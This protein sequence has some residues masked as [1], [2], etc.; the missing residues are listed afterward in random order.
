MKVSRNWLNKWVDVTSIADSE[1][2]KTFESLGYEVE[3]IIEI[4]P[5]Y[6][7]VVVGTVTNIQNHPN[8]DKIRIVDVDIGKNNLQIICGAWN[9][10]TNDKVAVAVPG[11]SIS[12]DFKIET[13]DI[14]GVT[15]NGMICSP[16]ELDLWSESE[17]ILILDESFINGTPLES[18]YNSKDTIYEI[19]ITP[20]RGDSMSHM[21]L[22]REISTKYNKKLNG[23]PIFRSTNKLPLIKVNNGKN[24]GCTSYFGLEIENITIEDSPLEI[25]FM[26]SNVGVRPINNFVDFTNYILFDIG[27]PLH[28]FDRDKLNGSISVRKAKNAETL[29]TLDGEKRNLTINDIVI[30]DN[31]I[32]IALAGVM[33]GLDTQ[34]TKN[35]ANVLI[36]SAHFD[37]VSILKTSRKLNLISEA[38]IRFERGVDPL[39]QEKSLVLFKKYLS[40]TNDTF[41]F[42]N[43]SGSRDKQKSLKNLTFDPIFYLS[44]IGVEISPKDTINILKKLGFDCIKHTNNTFMVSVPPWRYDIEREI[45]LVEELV[46]H[47]DYEELPST[48]KY[49]INH[50]IGQEWHYIDKISNDLVNMGYFECYNLSFSSLHDSKIFTPD[51]NPVTV[52]NPLDESQK[53]LRTSS[54]PNLIKNIITNDKIGNDSVPIF[55]IGNS[56]INTPS[57][58]DPT[59]PTQNNYL[60]LAIPASLN[61]SDKRKENISY[62]LYNLKNTINE[63]FGVDFTYKLLTRPGMHAKQSFTIFK[64][65]IN[66]GWMGKVSNEALNYFNM[67][68]NIFL[69]EINLENSQKIP[70]NHSKFKDISS[71]PFIKFDLSFLIDNDLTVSNILEHINQLYEDYENESYIFDEYF[72]SD[73]QN[74]TIGIRIKIRS[75]S[76][77]FKDENLVKIRENLISEI[78]KKYPAILK[79]NE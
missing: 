61:N 40:S 75:Y 6:K 23:L 37:N 15:S 70:T 72:D 52:S 17:G 11:A 41:K 29:V 66:I 44:T 3:K 42:N 24:S 36:E 71:Y 10:N 76:D 53:Y 18:T 67:K 56:F 21:G 73:N 64:D 16:N 38:S 7:N 51:R 43:I 78:T 45:D 77:S 48:V 54:I 58:Y 46:R 1:L 50:S 12:K 60:S 9:F 68:K 49:G 74:R 47:K 79:S 55:E 35:T 14:R 28:A 62:D 57:R 13:R 22:A 63:L 26:L 39:L 65:E 2:I 32:P 27:Q 59:I 4:N 30:V 19:S 34:I 33:G 31:D 20:N 69:A 5:S 8:A 25:R